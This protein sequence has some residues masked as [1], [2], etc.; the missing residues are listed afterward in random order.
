M[1]QEIIIVDGQRSDTKWTTYLA[2]GCCEGFEMEDAS[3]EEKLEAWAVL[4]KTKLAYSLQGWFGRAAN[5]LINQGLIS[6]DGIIDWDRFDDLIN[7]TL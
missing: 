4:I 3:N 5:D 2:T 6:K 7:E 1:E